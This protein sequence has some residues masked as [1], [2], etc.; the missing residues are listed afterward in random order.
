[1][2]YDLISYTGATALAE[3]LEMNRSLKALKLHYNNIG[4]VGSSAIAKALEVNKTLCVLNISC[5]DI[6]DHG[7]CALADMLR[8]NQSLTHLDIFQYDS[9]FKMSTES[10]NHFSESLCHNTTIKEI[11]LSLKLKIETYL[12]ERLK[13]S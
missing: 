3:G 11:N 6:G 8:R 5:N 4:G 10:I 2:E 9:D 7:A 12:D 13:F 1:M